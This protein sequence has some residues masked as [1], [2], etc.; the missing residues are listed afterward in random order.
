M[1]DGNGVKCRGYPLFAFVRSVGGNVFVVHRSRNPLAR[2]K[3]LNKARKLR[4]PEGS[5]MWQIDVTVGPFFRGSGAF[6]KVIM[7]VARNPE[8]RIVLAVLLAGAIGKGLK[9]YMS[10]A[11]RDSI[12]RS[13][14]SDYEGHTRRLRAAFTNP[15]WI[16]EIITCPLPTRHATRSET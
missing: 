12:I 14:D 6:R 7:T 4:V 2:L 3:K 13:L 11:T 8:T 15:Q 5:D 16:S 9:A 10:D 1:R